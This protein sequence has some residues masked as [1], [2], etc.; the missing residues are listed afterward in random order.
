MNQLELVIPA[1]RSARSALVPQPIVLYAILA[2]LSQV[3]NAL[4]LALKDSTSQLLVHASNV[5]Q[6]VKNVMALKTQ[7]VLSV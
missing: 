1:V 2:L 5:T 4:T 7:C 6:L 3:V